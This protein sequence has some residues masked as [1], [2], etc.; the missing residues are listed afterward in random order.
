MDNKNNEKGKSINGFPT[1]YGFVIILYFNY[2][3]K[4][5]LQCFDKV[6]AAKIS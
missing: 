6:C 2:K 4:Y 1:I 3:R 5:V